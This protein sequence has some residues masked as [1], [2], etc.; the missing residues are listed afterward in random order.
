MQQFKSPILKVAI[1]EA[2]RLVSGKIYWFCMIIAPLLCMVFFL[3]LMKEGLPTNL[4][5]ALVDID[6]STTS[7]SLA[8]QLDS[9]EGTEIIMH[10]SD[11]NEAKIEMQK[12][13]IYGI[14]FIPRDFEQEALS[15]NQPTL[16]YYTN[17]SY[18]IAGSL[19]FRDMKTVSTLAS[20]AVVLGTGRAKG[21][22][23]SQIMAQIQPISIDTHPLGNPWLNYSVYL[24]NIILPGIL[25][26][27]IMSVTVYS[28]GIEIKEHTRLDW[29]Y[30]G[31]GSIVR[32][33]IGK[34]LPQTLVFF[35]VGLIM[36]VV[37]YLVLQFPMGSFIAMVLAL[38]LLILSSQALGIFMIGILPTLR[39]GLS[40]ACIWGMIAFSAS[41]FSFPVI[42]MHPAIQALTNLFPLRHYFLIYVDQGL[43]SRDFVYS[44]P[45]YFA[46]AV[47]LILPVFV[48]KTLKHTL[49]YDSYK[50]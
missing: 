16:S 4:P 48:L 1:R 22:T 38:I 6:N 14:F 34:L 19:L 15:G 44:L 17:G 9:F 46:L 41:G 27:L 11:F 20:G 8:R 32:C 37:L 5:V 40:F 2:K 43:M 35:A 23:D 50:P 7:R 21:Y 36:Y 24:N 26:L 47:F 49:L 33:L 12:G 10:C 29:L 25:A 28:I 45:Q 39:L 31:K 3:S 13:N 18:L 30:A 42:A